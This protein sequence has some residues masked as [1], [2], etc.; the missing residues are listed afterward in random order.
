MNEGRERYEFEQCM[1][2]HHL[3]NLLGILVRRSDGEYVNPDIRLAWWAWEARAGFDVV[4][5]DELTEKLAA[6]QK[7]AERLAEIIT[8]M[9]KENPPTS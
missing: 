2:K 6:L 3:H 9:L 1:R 5:A 8:R 4:S 7:T